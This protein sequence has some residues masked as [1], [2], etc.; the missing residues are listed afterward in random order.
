[1]ASQT[2]QEESPRIS[3]SLL[4]NIKLFSARN[5]MAAWILLFGNL[6]LP[7]PCAALLS[8]DGMV[9]KQVIAE[10]ILNPILTAAVMELEP[11]QKMR[12]LRDNIL[13]T[14]EQVQ[15]VAKDDVIFRLMNGFAVLAIDQCDYMLSFGV[16]GFQHRSV[17]EPSSEVMQ[18]GSRE[19]FVEPLL[20][21]MSMIRRRMKTPKLKFESMIIGKDSQTNICL[22]YLRDMVSPGFFAC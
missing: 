4:E 9:N 8:I 21:N 15:L 12:Y 14:V 11:E 6:K 16:Q 1:M 19:G 3:S 2:P 5:L 18:R 13:S 17:S 22:C 10:S 20:V 7:A